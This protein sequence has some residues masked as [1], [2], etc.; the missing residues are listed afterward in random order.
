MLLLRLVL[1][2]HFPCARNTQKRLPSHPPPSTTWNPQSYPLGLEHVMAAW[3]HTAHCT[4]GV[5]A[6]LALVLD[7]SH[8]SKNSRNAIP[9]APSLPCGW[10]KRNQNT[11]PLSG[12]KAVLIGLMRFYFRVVRCARVGSIQQSRRLKGG[13]GHGRILEKTSGANFSNSEGGPH[14]SHSACVTRPCVRACMHA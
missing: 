7:Y 1:S 13:R 11:C 2:R 5:P 3:V 14:S 12:S 9:L 10:S 6:A 8:K 4:G